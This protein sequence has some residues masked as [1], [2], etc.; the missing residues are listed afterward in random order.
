MTQTQIRRYAFDA[1]V[2]LPTAR[3]AWASPECFSC[4]F[5]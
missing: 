3:S 4:M 1:V 2:S 5:C